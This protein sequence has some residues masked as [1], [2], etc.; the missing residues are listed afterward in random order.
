MTYHTY[1]QFAV[2]MYLL[3]YLG[4]IMTGLTLVTL[5]WAGVFSA[6]RWLVISQDAAPQD[7]PP[8]PSTTTIVPPRLY[9]D[10]Q[11]KVDEALLPLM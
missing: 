1:H 8:T 11:K 10:N 2:A 3:T 6:P 5:A 4:A 9:R 7:D